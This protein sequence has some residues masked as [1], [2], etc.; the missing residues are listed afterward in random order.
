MTTP[1]NGSFVGTYRHLL[2]TKG[3]LTIPARWRFAGDDDATTFL[4]L[5]NKDGSITVYPPKMVEQI[6]AK[7]E[8][9]GGPMGNPQES[10]ALAKVLATADYFGC[11]AQG[12][13]SIPEKLRRF[14]GLTKTVALVGRMTTFSLWSPELCPVP[15]EITRD[16]LNSDSQTLQ[17]FGL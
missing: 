12:R 11:D 16:T 15:E 1:S 9:A 4:A 14:A 17:K 10:D 5:P 3:R 8:A 7:I 6:R 13:I 2:D